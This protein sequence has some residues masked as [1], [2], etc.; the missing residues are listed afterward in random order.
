[1]LVVLRFPLGHPLSHGVG[2]GRTAQVIRIHPCTGLA[3]LPGPIRVIGLARP[4]GTVSIAGIIRP[5]GSARLPGT[6]RLSGLIRFPEPLRIG[7]IRLTGLLIPRGSSAV[8]G[9]I[10]VLLRG[11]ERR[12]QHPPGQALPAGGS[13]TGGSAPSVLLPRRGVTHVG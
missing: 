12:L 13:S 6:T 1:A 4:T 5:I 3:A 9:F 2:A 10:H 11:G 8:A 7:T